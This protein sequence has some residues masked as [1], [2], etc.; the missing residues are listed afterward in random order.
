MP[1]NTALAPKQ[2]KL[3][4]FLRDAAPMG[5]EDA[6]TVVQ[7]PYMKLLSALAP[8]LKKKTGG[9][10]NPKFIEGA[11]EGDFINSST[12]EI[13]GESVDVVCCYTRSVFKVWKKFESGGGYEGS[14][15]TEEEARTF[16]NAHETSE[17]L[18][19]QETDDHALLINNEPVVFSCARSKLWPSRSWSTAIANTGLCR[20]AK[21]WKLASF[22]KTSKKSGADFVTF[23]ASDTGD[24]VD[25]QT[26]DEAERL[27]Q[28]QSGKLENM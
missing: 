21:V 6:G 25:E 23:N 15:M 19:I 7:V 1:A 12:S 20:W 8:E 3:P 16:V 17:D 28:A 4:D 26:A 22:S 2:Q 24:F 9:Q 13:Y 11:E 14:F 5:N 18:E 10:T 27:Y